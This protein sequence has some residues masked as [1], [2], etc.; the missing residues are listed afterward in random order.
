MSNRCDWINLQGRYNYIYGVPTRALIDSGSQVCIVRQQ[1][2][3][4]V[5]DKYNWSLSDCIVHNLPLNNQ[6]VGAKGSVLGATALVNR[7]IIVEVTGKSLKVPCYVSDLTKQVWK[8]DAKN[9]GM[10]MGSNALV[11]FQFQILHANGI[12]VLPVNSANSLAEGSARINT[13]RFSGT[14]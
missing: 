8:G 11:A 14:D 12:E 4:V 3:P 5:K 6:P 1:L 7:E 13:C 9:C 10:I 2:L